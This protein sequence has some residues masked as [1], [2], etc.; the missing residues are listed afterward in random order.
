[1][2]KNK[3][4]ETKKNKIK[5]CHAAEDNEDKSKWGSKQKH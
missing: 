3:G 4:S 2:K 1:M 5:E